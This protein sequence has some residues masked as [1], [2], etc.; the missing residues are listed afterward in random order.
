MQHSEVS[1]VGN[2][3]GHSCQRKG[4]MMD[5]RKL[6]IFVVLVGCSVVVV[7]ANTDVSLTDRGEQNER[8]QPKG[9]AKISELESYL[10]QLS[11]D[12]EKKF[13]K[14]RQQRIEHYLQ[15]ARKYQKS[16]WQYNRDDALTRA[17]NI[18]EHHERMT[19]G[20]YASL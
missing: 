2:K 17:K 9:P 10:A 5:Y 3:H 1:I 20:S 11:F 4:Q 16:D 19:N 6:L 12:E 8:R 15:L 14:I 13:H 7:G 18:L